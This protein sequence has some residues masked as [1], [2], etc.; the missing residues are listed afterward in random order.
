MFSP[1]I[2]ESDAFLDMPLSSQAL[3][4]HLGMFAD[5]DGF[6]NPN[7]IVRMLGNSA[8][9]FKVLV[10]KRFVLPFESGIIVVK[11]WKVN[12]LV[13]KDWYKPSQYLEEKAMLFLKDNGIYTFDS[14]QGTP[15]VNEPLTN[16]SRRLGKV[17]IEEENISSEESADAPKD[18][19][20]KVRFDPIDVEI[21]QSLFDAIRVNLPSFKQPN[22]DKWAD[23]VR[24]MR[25]RDSRTVEQIKF[26]VNWCQKDS[27]WK[28]NILSTSKLRDKF[29]QLAAQAIR[30]SK[31]GTRQ[32]VGRGVA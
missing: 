4:F 9:D 2:V 15:L 6:V 8:D 26:L 17:R 11:H 13:R 28:A 31:G 23:Y 7:R 10:S 24:L 27:F 22:L 18:I 29:D 19:P 20:Q 32:P 12:N 16:R 21:A 30:N 25:V 1:Q 3:Y 5:D 14:S